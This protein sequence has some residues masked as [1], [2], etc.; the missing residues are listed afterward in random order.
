MVEELEGPYGVRAG[1]SL[2]CK[3]G[4]DLMV[5]EQEG[6]Y[7]VRA[8]GTLW[9]KSRMDL[10]VTCYILIWYIYKNITVAKQWNFHIEVT[11]KI[12]S[13]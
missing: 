6:P 5:E 2:W 10:M 11:L 12:G 1:G 9:W 4:R 7:G 8:E 3:S 13:T